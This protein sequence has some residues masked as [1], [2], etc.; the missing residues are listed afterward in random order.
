MVIHDLDFMGIAGT[1][2]KADP[3]LIVD[4][5]AVLAGAVP[6]QFFQPVAW[7]DTKIT[8]GLRCVQYPKFPES[9]TLDVRSEL[10]NGMTPKKPFRI[11]ITKALDHT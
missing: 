8:K 11:P 1:P 3:P 4:P 7:G 5:D 6:P 9:H 2:T 10:P